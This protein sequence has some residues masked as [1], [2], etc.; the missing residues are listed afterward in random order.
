MLQLTA[1]CYWALGVYLATFL[2]AHPCGALL[3]VY[4]TMQ[5]LCGF[6]EDR[7]QKVT[8]VWNVANNGSRM[9]VLGS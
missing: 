5:H 6:I 9:V 3:A 4:Y 7:R 2:S 8:G 1:L